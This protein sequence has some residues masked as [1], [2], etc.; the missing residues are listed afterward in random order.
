[1]TVGGKDPEDVK[2]LVQ[3]ELNQL[4]N[5]PLREALL[6]FLVIPT[7]Q[8]RFAGAW[9]EKDFKH[10]SARA[11]D[12]ILKVS[13]TIADLEG[14]KEI[15]SAQVAEALGYRSLD[16]TYWTRAQV[17]SVAVAEEIQYLLG[18]VRQRRA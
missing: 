7:L 13:R 11:Y 12:R 16:R 2:E 15:R 10:L 17:E 3:W 8:M 9:L 1:M 4:T 6:A 5:G 18:R 14:S